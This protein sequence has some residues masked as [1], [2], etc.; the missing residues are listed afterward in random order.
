MRQDSR[1]SLIYFPVNTD[2]SCALASDTGV[3]FE[4]FAIGREGL[5]GLAPFLADEPYAWSLTNRGEGH[6]YTIPATDLRR[7]MTASDG[8]QLQLHRLTH[9]YQR[10]SGKRALEGAHDSALRRLARWLVDAAE[11]TGRCDFPLTQEDLSQLLGLQRSTIS[12]SASALRRSG[13][14]TYARGRLSISDLKGL[15]AA[16]AP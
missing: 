15:K 6:L 11:R 14:I 1:P 5:S 12:E 8:L 7:R 16:I 10:Q 2:L 13:L 3:A 9:A 4:V